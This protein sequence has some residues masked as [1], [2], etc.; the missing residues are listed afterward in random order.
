MDVLAWESFGKG[1][2]TDIVGQLKLE[3]VRVL[4]ADYGEIPDLATV[5]CDRDVVFTWNGTTSGVRVPDGDWIAPDRGGLTIC[6]AT[7]AVYAMELPWDRLDVT[8][9][10]W[11]KVLG[12]EA[13]QEPL[14]DLLTAEIPERLDTGTDKDLVDPLIE[15]RSCILGNRARVT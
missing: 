5:D 14:R 10:S 3:D 4:E 1:W 7:S 2:V 12:G 11:Q 8:T 9:Y 6:D 15:M 13:Q